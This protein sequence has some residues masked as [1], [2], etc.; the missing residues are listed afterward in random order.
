MPKYFISD[1]KNLDKPTI[2]HLKNVLRYKPGDSLIIC[3]GHCADYHCIV[4]S[5]EPF[6]LEAEDKFECGNELPVKLA[7]FQSLTK[8]DKLD[9]IIQKAVEIGVS[10]IYP[11]TTERSVVKR[12]IDKSAAKTARYQKIAESAAGQ[13]M[14]GIIPS[15]N[16]AITFDEAVSI[17]KNAFTIVAYENEKENSLL[18]IVNKNTEKA[19]NIWIG[20]EGG[21]SA[22]EIKI[23]EK[24]GFEIISL[25]KRILRSETAA[26]AALAVIASAVEC[27][28]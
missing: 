7:L 11:I 9:L 15:I 16:Q 3:D 18:D 21:F 1:T 12:D 26:I 19:I 2:H 25:G 24:E 5:V 27:K 6:T 13:S 23:M 17:S 4:K 22:G 20:P 28:L 14:R 10:E 8:G